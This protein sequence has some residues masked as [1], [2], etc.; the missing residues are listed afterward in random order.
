[1]RPLLGGP[2]RWQK[3]TETHFVDWERQ[4]FRLSAF[5]TF[6]HNYLV[7]LF[8][9]LTFAREFY[10][11]IPLKIALRRFSKNLSQDSF[12]PEKNFLRKR[13]RKTYLIEFKEN[14]TS[15]GNEKPDFFNIPINLQ[16][17]SILFY[18][19]SMLQCYASL[20]PYYIIRS[21]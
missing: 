12:F 9:C 21:T 4:E 15:L 20:F 14:L 11:C 2:I 5:F 7:V 1:M 8:V 16:R 10:I 19:N 18:S 3:L 17:N 13:S 6:S